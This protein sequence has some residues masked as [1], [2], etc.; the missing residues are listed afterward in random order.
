MNAP[1]YHLRLNKAVDRFLLIDLLRCF[2]K[3]DLGDYSYVGLG[4][5]FLEDFKLL[6]SFFPE[7]RKISFELDEQTF[8]RQQFN[9]HTRR[10]RLERGDM[11]S[12]IDGVISDNKPVVVWYDST[13]ATDAIF[14]GFV[15]LI[16]KVPN[17]SIVRV[18]MRLGRRDSNPNRKLIISLSGALRT[19][20]SSLSIPDDEKKLL[21]NDIERII[22]DRVEESTQFQGGLDSISRYLPTD[23]RRI[24]NSTNGLVKVLFKA[25]HRAVTE[26][27]PVGCG[28][29]FRLLNASYYSDGTKMLSVTGAVVPD[30]EE[31]E[32]MKR[33]EGT[34]FSQT[35]WSDE[36]IQIDMPILTPK[37]RL[38]LNKI[39]PVVKNP[40]RRLCKRLGFAIDPKAQTSENEMEM[41]NRFYRY[42]PVFAKVTL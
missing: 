13:Q 33:F 16:D 4:G 22:K 17:K 21:M 23:F 11:I 28:R 31:K 20:L 15:S 9:K 25:I 7:L 6:E 26:T 27:F 40:G 2:G 32:F 37:E 39:V 24:L 1:P 29:M 18:T 34:A 42:Y 30:L 19:K 5:P 3:G 35:K 10:V 8:R 38:H 36:P 41:Y 12:G 14:D